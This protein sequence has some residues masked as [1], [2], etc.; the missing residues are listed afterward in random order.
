MKFSW[1]EKL[2]AIKISSRNPQ[3]YVLVKSSSWI[4]ALFLMDKNKIKYY[5]VKNM[6]SQNFLPI[7]I[8]HKCASTV[9]KSYKN[10]PVWNECLKDDK[11]F[12]Q[13]RC[14]SLP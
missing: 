8:T 5:T 9:T 3:K 12:L 6:D 1:E 4:M 11:C 13:T 2:I 10:K 7:H 14:I